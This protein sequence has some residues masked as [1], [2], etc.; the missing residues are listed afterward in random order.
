MVASS[1]CN[2]LPS[3]VKDFP[4]PSSIAAWKERLHSDI[5][6]MS[7]HQ[8]CRFGGETDATSPLAASG[9]LR[10]LKTKDR[11]RFRKSAISE[12]ECPV[13]KETIR[14]C[15]FISWVILGST[16]FSHKKTQW[17]ILASTMLY[18]WRGVLTNTCRTLYVIQLK[19][20]VS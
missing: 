1:M 14:A 17:S 19:R 5:L 15:L 2:Y 12:S 7:V 11:A 13:A 18:C 20:K 3:S 6:I 9:S 10:T 4:V 8:Q 16:I